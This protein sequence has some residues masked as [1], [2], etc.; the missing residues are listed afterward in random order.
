[1]SYEHKKLEDMNLLDNFLF[2]AVMTHPEYGESFSKVILRTVLECDV[3]KLS[4]YPQRVFYGSNVSLHGARLDVYL[5]EN[6]EEQDGQD[7]ATVYDVEPDKNQDKVAV[8]ALPKR[9]RFYHA[10]ISARCLKA[11]EKYD[12]LKEVVIIMILPYDP[13]ERNRMVYTVKNCCL[14]EPEMPYEDGAKTIYL[15]TKGERGKQSLKLEQLLTFMESTVEENAVNEELVSLY[16][17]V[18]EI[19]KDEEVSIRFMQMFEDEE[20]IMERARKAGIKE[21]IEQGIEQGIDIL[22]ADNME[23]GATKGI[24]IQKLMKH[25]KL[26]RGEAEERYEKARCVLQLT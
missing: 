21:G 6:R 13:F 26:T 15:Y 8:K 4:V 24:I 14:E 10:K 22:V 7:N 9:V 23:M 19:K 11:G 25:Y 1:M 18:E 20:V 12:R 16:A 2:G 3:E 5:E 17:M